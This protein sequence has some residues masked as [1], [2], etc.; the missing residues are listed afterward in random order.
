MIS[1]RLFKII[2]FTK[3][4]LPVGNAVRWGGVSNVACADIFRSDR[5]RVL[6]NTPVMI[7][8]FVKDFWSFSKNLNENKAVVTKIHH[9]SH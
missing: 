6:S 7:N 4:C 2:N 1:V 9:N 5:S 3:N 8:A